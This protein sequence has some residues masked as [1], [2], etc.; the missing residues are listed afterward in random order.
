MEAGTKKIQSI[1]YPISE[2]TNNLE[3]T[4]LGIWKSQLRL[5]MIR[6]AFKSNMKR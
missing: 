3:G 6:T 4:N 1:N 2:Q 5:P